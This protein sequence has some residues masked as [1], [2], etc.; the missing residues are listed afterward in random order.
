MHRLGETD[1]GQTELA[2]RSTLS[3]HPQVRVIINIYGGGGS[4]RRFPAALLLA[5]RFGLR[6]VDIS[7]KGI[8]IQRIIG[9]VMEGAEGCIVTH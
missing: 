8:K 1:L 9:Q 7:Q 4:L 3:K 6:Q 5:S 2:Y